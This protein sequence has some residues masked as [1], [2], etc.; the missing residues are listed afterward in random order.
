MAQD[1]DKLLLRL[2]NVTSRLESISHNATPSSGRNDSL[3]SAASNSRDNAEEIP[4]SIVAFD[5]LIKSSFQPFKELSA[6]VG[7]DVK[8]IVT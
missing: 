7:D 4:P 5:E 2:E 8:Q 1:L 6:K 3:P